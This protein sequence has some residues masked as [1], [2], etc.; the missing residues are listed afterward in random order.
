V[1]REIPG[2]ERPKGLQARAGAAIAMVGAPATVHPRS[3]VLLALSDEMPQ[4]AV[5]LPPT[6]APCGA[7]LAALSDPPEMG[8]R[9]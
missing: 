3:A 5:T 8:R 6:I 9:K 7:I 4:L 1:T 2:S